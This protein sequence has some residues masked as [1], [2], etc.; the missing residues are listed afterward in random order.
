MPTTIVG[1]RSIF[2][3]VGSSVEIGDYKTKKPVGATVNYHDTRASL[4]IGKDYFRSGTVFGDFSSASSTKQDGVASGSV[5]YKTTSDEVVYTMKYN[6][7]SEPI[8]TH[9]DFQKFAGD[10]DN[11]LHGA[12]FEP[13]GAFRKFAHKLSKDE[14]EALDIDGGF[15]VRNAKGQAAAEGD[16]NWFS[17]VSSYLESSGVWTKRFKSNRTPTLEGL[18]KISTPDGY[19]PVIEGRNWLYTGFT[20]SFTSPAKADK[21]R[22]IKGDISMEWTLSGRRGWDKDIYGESAPEGGEDAPVNIRGDF[23][24]QREEGDNQLKGDVLRNGINQ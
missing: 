4:D 20:A 24:E 3:T 7:S 9:P 21:N 12:Q 17:G 10:G 18:G 22:T 15:P 6:T 2:E 16:Q 19:C 14:L 11:P 8:D 13:N 5:N 23:A 1:E